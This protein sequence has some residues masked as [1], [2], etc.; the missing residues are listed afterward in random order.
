MTLGDIELFCGWVCLQYEYVQMSS[1]KIENICW[2]KGTLIKSMNK[3]SS[4]SGSIVKLD[5]KLSNA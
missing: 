4:V 5:M 2:R 3:I 1:I